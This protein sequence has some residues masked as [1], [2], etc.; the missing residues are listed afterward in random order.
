MNRKRQLRKRRVETMQA[1]V[2]GV[3]SRR[4][5][6]LETVCEVQVWELNQD[7]EVRIL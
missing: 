6:E 5:D 2:V 4:L 1:A 7:P 3:C